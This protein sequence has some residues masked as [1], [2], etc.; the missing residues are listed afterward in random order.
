MTKSY[1]PT[2]AI[3]VFY[4]V[5]C[6]SSTHN[7]FKKLLKQK[8]KKQ[9]IFLNGAQINRSGK[10]SV[11]QGVSEIVFKGISPYIN[12]QSIQIKAEGIYIS[13]FCSA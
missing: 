12:K 5:N 9:L 3:Y 6:K 13:T 8:L 10:T 1:Y 11:T 7:L 2:A 4:T